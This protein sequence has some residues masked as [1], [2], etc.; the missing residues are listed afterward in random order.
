MTLGAVI[1]LQLL[2]CDALHKAFSSVGGLTD[3][4]VVQGAV[5]GI[6][7]PDDPRI[8]PL[9]E[10]TDFAP[11]TAVTV[12]VAD[13]KS[14]ADLGNAP[15]DGGVVTVSGNVA[16]PVPG[17]GGGLYATDPS[18]S[19]LEYE[20]GARWVVDVNTDGTIGTALLDLPA[21]AAFE[22][23]EFHEPGAPM[24]IDLTGQGFHSSV[25]V[26]ISQEGE[27]TWTNTPTDIRGLYEAMDSEEAG[28]IE[29]PGSAFA[30]EGFYAV[31]VAA[32]THTTA[33]DLAGINTAL[34]KLRVGKMRVVPVSTIPLPN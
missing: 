32:M 17:Q 3:A 10:G 18:T 31:G 29:I 23:D 7:M 30:G 21:A 34:S 28:V 25:A 19:N 13:A 16:E 33:E 4:T 2:G 26:V 1:L 20:D 5:L 12:F 14:I 22:V 11:G 8:A 9:L 27:V 15:V 6:E 24:T